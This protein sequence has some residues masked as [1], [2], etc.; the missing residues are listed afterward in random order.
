MDI[1]IFCSSARGSLLLLSVT[2]HAG[3]PGEHWVQVWALAKVRGKCSE[4][5]K[6][7]KLVNHHGIALRPA[8]ANQAHANP[9]NKAHFRRTEFSLFLDL[10]RTQISFFYSLAAATVKVLVRWECYKAYRGLGKRLIFYPGSSAGRTITFGIVE[11][12]SSNPTSN[13]S[14]RRSAC[15]CVL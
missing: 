12:T 3:G 15:A 2:V 1:G 9:K 4:G 11:D 5:S 14:F 10:H 8:R 7:Q 6:S 13:I